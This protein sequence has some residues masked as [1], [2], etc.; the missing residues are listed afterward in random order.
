[1]KTDWGS[2]AADD[3]VVVVVVVVAV[4]LAVAVAGWWFCCI[5]NPG[6]SLR[7]WHNISSYVYPF[8]GFLETVRVFPIF[9][10]AYRPF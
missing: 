2:A 5:S 10:S 3:K 9:S 8:R 6:L 7:L 1:M 4:A